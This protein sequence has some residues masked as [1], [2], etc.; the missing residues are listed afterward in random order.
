MAIC[1]WTV[2]DSLCC[3]TW[4]TYSPALQAAALDY[5]TT[6]L[7]ASTGR[8]F[9]LCEKSIRPCGTGSPCGNGVWA[10]NGWFASG[11]GWLPY[12]F[13]GEWFNC[14]CAGT[15]SC[16][17]TC[18]VLLPEPVES[19]SSVTI[20]G[21][22]INASAWRVDN[23]R[24]LVRTDGDCWPQCPDMNTDTGENVFVVNYLRGTPVPTA[25]LTAAATLAC[26]FAKACSSDA[27]CRLPSRIQQ[28][29]RQ[30]VTVSFVDVDELLEKGFTGIQEVDALIRAYNPDG[31]THRPRVRTPDI[32]PGREVTTP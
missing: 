2:P 12:I 23:H 32:R 24:W 27:T 13:N 21:I 22:A 14:G 5:A 31:K 17:P 7:W 18:Q 26:E 20:G 15:C 11:G 30:G 1:P 6:V 4:D 9:G 16:D 29:V 8:Q 19:V 28:L 3:S 25:L 10:W